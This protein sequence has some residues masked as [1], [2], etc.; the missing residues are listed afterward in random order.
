[1]TGLAPGESS[2]WGRISLA[3]P[4][5]DV[6]TLC[7]RALLSAPRRYQVE[8]ELRRSAIQFVFRH[9]GGTADCIAESSDDS[10][11]QSQV[12]AAIN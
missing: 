10:A 7:G 12:E 1:M 3:E 2:S 4:D 6:V 11:M 9:S 8:A 5:S